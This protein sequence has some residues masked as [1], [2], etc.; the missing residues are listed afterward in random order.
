MRVFNM[1]AFK[2]VFYFEVLFRLVERRL[3]GRKLFDAVVVSDKALYK[4]LSAFRKSFSTP[5]YFIK[6]DP[7]SAEDTDRRW[8]KRAVDIVEMIKSGKEDPKWGKGV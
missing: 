8:R 6:T 5:I 3:K 4:F 1:S 7:F 2:P